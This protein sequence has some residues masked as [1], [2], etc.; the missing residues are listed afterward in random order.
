ME[1]SMDGDKLP[2][3]SRE[4]KS[5]VAYMEW[6]GEGLP[7]D[8]EKE[9]KGFPEIS[10]PEVA[11][12]LEKGKD[13]FLKNVPFVMEKM[14]RGSVLQILPRDINT[15]LFGGQTVI[16]MVQGCIG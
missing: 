12:D 16:I 1:R 4:M 9:F 5:I 3:L 11:V 7:K 14:E 2:V 6:L 13:Y 10:I 15:H 8:R